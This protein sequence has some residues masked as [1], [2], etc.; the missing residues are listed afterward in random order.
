MTKSTL[1]TLA[2]SIASPL[3]H[4]TPL[5]RL[6]SNPWASSFFSD[7]RSP[8]CL[9]NSSSFCL[10]CLSS[11]SL[12]LAE[13]VSS[14]EKSMSSQMMPPHRCVYRLHNTCR[15]VWLRCS[16]DFICNI[17]SLGGV[18]ALPWPLV[19]LS[20]SAENNVS[21]HCKGSINI[22]WRNN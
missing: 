15:A 1:P 18:Q 4:H 19:L 12:G 7:T 2:N 6:P 9:L 10:K 20:T 11:L 22:W 5:R 14:E 8:H 21:E 13:S 3:W 16:L 17:C